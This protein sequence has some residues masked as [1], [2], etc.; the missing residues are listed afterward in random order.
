MTALLI[1]DHDP[2]RDRV[3]GGL[4]AMLIGGVVTDR[5]IIWTTLSPFLIVI[6]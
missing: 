2:R 6:S 1:L 4:V 5:G 3:V